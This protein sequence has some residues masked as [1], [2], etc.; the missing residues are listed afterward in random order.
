MSWLAVPRDILASFGDIMK[1]FWAVIKEV[2][3][4]SAVRFFGETL[5]QAGILI[6]GSALVIWGMAFILGLTCGVN[7]AYF[8]RSIGSLDRL[9]G[10]FVLAVIR[11][12]GPAITAVILV[13]VGG[14][15]ITA[16]LGAR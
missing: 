13:G 1:F 14:T 2:M 3:E 7:G 4:G 16:D 11:A 8:A 12:I 10:F 5:R 6:I 9:G 15:A